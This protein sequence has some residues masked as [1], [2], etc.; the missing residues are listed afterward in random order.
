MGWG[1]R[2]VRTKTGIRSGVAAGQ[3]YP[4][5]KC[6]LWNCSGS[7][8]LP[9]RA[10]C[11]CGGGSVANY[12]PGTTSRRRIG[13][14]ATRTQWSVP[15]RVRRGASVHRRRPAERGPSRSAEPRTRPH[16]SG[17]QAQ[18]R[19]LAQSPQSRGVSRSS[20]RKGLGSRRRQPWR[21]PGRATVL[22]WSAV[23]AHG[24]PAAKPAPAAF[25]PAFEAVAIASLGRGA[26]RAAAAPEAVP[27]PAPASGSPVAHAAGPVAGP[28]ATSARV[29]ARR[30]AAQAARSTAKWL[31]GQPAA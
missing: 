26:A 29:S 15:G 20:S 10:G 17:A 27:W 23:A 2:I 4:P 18:L 7:C 13:W 19:W 11:A 22:H 30:G 28:A 8:G 3:Y 31:A 21:G 12:P 6:R 5:C 9:R 24:R 14:T 1:Q 25:G 16:A